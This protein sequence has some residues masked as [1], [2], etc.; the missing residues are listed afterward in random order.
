MS[1][2]QKL[3]LVSLFLSTRYVSTHIEEYASKSFIQERRA[4]GTGECQR[5]K[6]STQKAFFEIFKGLNLGNLSS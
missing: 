6:D 2:A 1:Q 3:V 5:D 4:C